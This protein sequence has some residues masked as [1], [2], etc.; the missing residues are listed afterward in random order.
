[1]ASAPE[2]PS[3]PDDADD[4]DALIHASSS[5]VRSAHGSHGLGSSRCPTRRMAAHVP[6]RGVGLGAGVAPGRGARRPTSGGGGEPFVPPLELSLDAS[7]ERTERR[8]WLVVAL[9]CGRRRLRWT[10]RTGD[11]RQRG[12]R[13]RRGGGR[14]RRGG[15][16][17]GR[18]R[19]RGERGEGRV[20]V[21][22]EGGEVRMGE[23]GE[24]GGRGEGGGQEGGGRPGGPLAQGRHRLP[25]ISLETCGRAGV[26]ER[27]RD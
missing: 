2:E 19:G 9:G 3:S 8:R 21:R 24:G 12:R 14:G 11:G 16:V 4:A 26:S 20:V 6:A 22:G 23:G 27:A 1:M 5:C 10:A 15:G 25:V 18:G 7:L 13:G 17:G